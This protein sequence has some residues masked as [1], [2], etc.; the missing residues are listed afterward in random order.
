[1]IGQ[2]G[3]GSPEAG[4]VLRAD[5]HVLVYTLW[6]GTR[7]DTQGSGTDSRVQSAVSII[8]W[9][10]NKFLFAGS[11]T[12]VLHLLSSAMRQTFRW[13]LWH[14]CAFGS[15][16]SRAQAELTMKSNRNSPDKLF[17]C[18]HRVWE[19]RTSS[20]FYWGGKSHPFSLSQTLTSCSGMD[21]LWVLRSVGV[22]QSRVTIYQN[23]HIQHQLLDPLAFPFF[24]QA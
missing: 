8:L 22:W 12:L 5:P 14:L 19:P 21:V 24:S 11:R 9:S 13:L 7:R 3:T 23:N 1:M 17:L 18:N 4:I 20:N 6:T 2:A 16:S 15:R 10:Q